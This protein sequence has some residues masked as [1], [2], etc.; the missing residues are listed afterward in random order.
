M[1]FSPEQSNGA[2]FHPKTHAPIAQSA[3]KYVLKS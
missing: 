3:R 1:D 2:W